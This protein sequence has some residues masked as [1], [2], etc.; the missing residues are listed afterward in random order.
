MSEALPIVFYAV[1]AI[2]LLSIVFAT[3]LFLRNPRN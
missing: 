3:L 1:I 2:A